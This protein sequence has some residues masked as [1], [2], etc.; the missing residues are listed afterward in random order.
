MK[1]FLLGMASALLL[2]FALTPAHALPDG[3]EGDIAGYG[4]FVIIMSEVALDNPPPEPMDVYDRLRFNFDDGWDFGDRYGYACA[5]AEFFEGQ[6]ERFEVHFEQRRDYEFDFQINDKY[7]A[8]VRGGSSKDGSNTLCGEGV[9]TP[10]GVTDKGG[11]PTH[12]GSD[13][14]PHMIHAGDGLS[15][16]DAGGPLAFLPLDNAPCDKAYW[17]P[18]DQP[19]EAWLWW[20]E[21]GPTGSHDHTQDDLNCGGGQGEP[22]SVVRLIVQNADDNV[23]YCT[24]SAHEQQCSSGGTTPSPSPSPTPTPLDRFCEQ[25]P[26]HRR[27]D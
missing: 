14:F 13:H 17:V 23:T 25:H 27:C 3:P 22:V 26:N 12:D 21:D 19:G 16:A 24:V 11:V 9:S 8:E 20:D 4:Y 6:N 2:A 15:F 10:G 5:W 7:G 1:K 18:G